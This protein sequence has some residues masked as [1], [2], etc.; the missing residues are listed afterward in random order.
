MPG[1]ADRVLRVCALALS[2]VSAKASPAAA[3]GISEQVPFEYAH[4]RDSI[5]LHVQVNQKP[6]LLILDTG[7]PYT[8]LRPEVVGLDPKELTPTRA[9]SGGR[10]IGDAAEKEVSL[11]VGSLKWEKRKV[12]VMDLSQAFSAYREDIAGVLGLDILREFDQITIDIKDKA[13]VFVGGRNPSR[14]L[15]PAQTS[16][17]EPSVG[18]LRKLSLDGGEGHY[19]LNG[20]ALPRVLSD[21]VY[22]NTPD[23]AYQVSITFGETVQVARGKPVDPKSSALLESWAQRVPLVAKILK[24]Q[25]EMG[26]L[27]LLLYDLIEPSG[28]A[29]LQI[30]EEIVFLRSSDPDDEKLIGVPNVRPPSPFPGRIVDLQYRGLEKPGPFFSKAALQIVYVRSESSRFLMGGFLIVSKSDG[31]YEFYLVPRSVL[32]RI[33]IEDK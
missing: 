8:V 18:A 25:D 6:A 14:D 27:T 7:S 19:K 33:V 22:L 2:L 17:H 13:V 12:V 11:Q 21:K 32:N 31:G 30:Q 3:A 23:G 1:K 29:S 15:S 26:T 5:L 9:A 16:S 20:V 4:G 24:D 28:A 10:F